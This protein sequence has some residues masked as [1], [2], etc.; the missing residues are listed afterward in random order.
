MKLV[1]TGVT[2]FSQ[3]QRYLLRVIEHQGNSFPRR[4]PRRRYRDFCFDVAISFLI[5]PHIETP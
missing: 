5:T 4:P 1:Y 2:I 3:L